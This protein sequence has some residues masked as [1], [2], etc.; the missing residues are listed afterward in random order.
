MFNISGGKFLAN[1]GTLWNDLPDVPD[2]SS[3]RAPMIIHPNGPY[4][5]SNF[6]STSYFYS[7]LSLE[8]TSS[9]EV[10]DDPIHLYQ[11]YNQKFVQIYVS[12]LDF[13]AMLKTGISPILFFL[14]FFKS[15]AELGI[16]RYLLRVYIIMA[17]AYGFLMVG[18][19]SDE[20]VLFS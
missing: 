14:M 13:S 9:T 19:E 5:H 18:N 2:K 7:N 12:S 11:I 10:Y 8:S 4:F 1:H 15:T 6:S 16:Y 17:Y 20:I 3:T